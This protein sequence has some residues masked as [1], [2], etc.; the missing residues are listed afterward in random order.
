MVPY[1]IIPNIQ[2][3]QVRT[4]TEKDTAS[5][6]GSGHVDVFATP[7]MVALME[8]TARDSVQH[9]LPEGYTTV[10]TEVNIKH[11]RPSAVGHEVRCQSKVVEVSGQKILF[12]LQVW[13]DSI[14]VG[15]GSHTRAIVDLERFMQKL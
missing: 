6:Y 8:M 11:L 14:L 9:L 3:E 7:A 10:G 12:E 5:A 1:N 4:V 15:H 13:D 2:G